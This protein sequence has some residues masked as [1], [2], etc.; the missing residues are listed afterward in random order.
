L[1]PDP[2]LWITLIQKTLYLDG[3]SFTFL[4]MNEQMAIQKILFTKYEEIRIRN[5]QY[6][7]RAFSKKL[8]LSAGAMSELFNGRRRVSAK[9]AER[10]A[11]RL[12]LDPQERADLFSH[13]PDEKRHT[14]KDEVDPQYLQLSADQFRVIGDWYHFAILTLM[15]TSKFKSNASWVG[16][17]LG[18]SSS[19][20]QSAIGR[21]IRVNLIHVTKTG[22]W[23]R[24][25][26]RYRTS[27]DVAK[28]SVQ[29]AHFQYLDQ[30][31]EALGKF[32]V[33]ERDF[34]SLMMA[35][36]PEQ[37]PIAK[38]KIRKFQDELSKELESK[39]Q[40]EVYQLCIQLFPLTKSEGA[41]K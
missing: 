21:L 12:S 36:S 18:L 2:K 38:E 16:R 20:V 30:A 37:I 29:R 13:F 10:L 27:D 22:E 34:T 1:G 3:T 8:G 26:T 7:R 40:A 25:K 4:S 9:L 35:L 23:K 14:S 5:P 28:L 33:K 6:S 19:V 15:R 41:K 17:R 24:S 32:S 39:P 11:T 31:R